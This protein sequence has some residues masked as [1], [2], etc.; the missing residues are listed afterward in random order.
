MRAPTPWWCSVNAA[1]WCPPDPRR[2]SGL[3][4]VVAT[5]AFARSV[6]GAF[7]KSATRLNSTA[8]SFAIS[9]LATIDLPDRALTRTGEVQT[10]TM[11]SGRPQ[12][13][14][15]FVARRSGRRNESRP[16]IGTPAKARRAYWDLVL[17]AADPAMG[18]DPSLKLAQLALRR[19]LYL[20]REMVSIERKAPDA[21]ALV[22]R[23]VI[24]TALVGSY[25]AVMPSTSDRFVKKQA[26]HSRRLRERLLAGDNAGVLALLAE[27]DFIAEPLAP[28]L[29][30][31]RAAPD[32]AQIARQLDSV[33]PFDQGALATHLY[34]E[35]YSFLSNF[36]EHPTPLSLNRHRDRQL[37]SLRLRPFPPKPRMPAPTLT[38]IAMPAVAALGACLARRAHRDPSLLDE[39]A[40]DASSADGYFWSGSPLRMAAALSIFAEVSLSRSRANAAGFAVRLLAGSDHIRTL[41]S[42]E[43]LAVALD[44]IELAKATNPIVY[45][46]RGS[47]RRVPQATDWRGLPEEELRNQTEAALGALMLSYAGL[48]P[49]EPDLLDGT[50][51][52]A[53]A[54]MA[55]VV[56]GALIRVIA[57]PPRL[58]VA[59][60]R[61]RQ[62]AAAFD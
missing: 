40:R 36:V 13:F 27:A 21:S 3:T 35:S 41:P 18:P 4:V 61:F 60:Q 26:K 43:Q 56:P 47:D 39:W 29:D 46:L 14:A 54:S 62:R 15:V 50:L 12:S 57:S 59:L 34:D 28:H 24:E 42:A 31:E 44:V 17:L 11:P 49:T 1:A 48:W 7:R 19:S 53:S 45:L 6:W 2:G 23:S 22:A 20:L 33:P 10:A 16:S 9:R 37:L 32:L 5:A 25:L 51:A 8:H 30:N 58:G 38:H 55:T 52:V